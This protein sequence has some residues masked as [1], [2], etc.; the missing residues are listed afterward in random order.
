VVAIVTRL[1][2]FV[3]G[4][5]AFALFSLAVVVLVMRKVGGGSF[6]E[7]VG[8]VLMFLT[9]SIFI[10]QVISQA[11]RT[12]RSSAPPL[13]RSLFKALDVLQFSSIAPPP[14]CLD[15]LHPFQEYLINYSVSMLLLLIAVL[16]A[17]K[18]DYSVPSRQVSCVASVYRRCRPYIQRSTFILLS[19]LYVLT[20]NSTLEM[21]HCK[22]TVLTVSRYLE[23]DQHGAAIVELPAISPSNIVACE[24]DPRGPGCDVVLAHAAMEIKVDV[25]DINPQYVCYEKTHLQVIWFAYLTLIVYVIGYPVGSFLYVRHRIRGTMLKGHS[26]KEWN[27]ALTAD[28][29]RRKRYVDDAPNCGIRLIRVIRAAYFRTGS[30][31]EG[32][33]RGSRGACS[34]SCM[35]FGL[36]IADATV[37]KSPNGGGGATRTADDIMDENADIQ[38]DTAISPFAADVYRTSFFYQRHLD[39]LCLAALSFLLVFAKHHPRLQLSVALVVLAIHTTSV[40]LGRPFTT[41]ASFNHSVRVYANCLTMLGALVSFLSI[42]KDGAV[43]SVPSKSLN[44]LGPLSYVML[45]ACIGLSLLLLVSFY[46]TLLR[47]ARLD[48]ERELQ[49]RNFLASSSRRLPGINPV[50]DN[51]NNR[52]KTPQPF[53]RRAFA[54]LPHPGADDDLGPDKSGQRFRRILGRKALAKTD[55]LGASFMPRKVRSED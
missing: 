18:G 45:A 52:K 26:A 40:L 43:G 29:M 16:L 32:R 35:L 13:I 22:T 42:T 14:D 25:L 36:R 21:L 51:D 20:V 19:L 46:S 50:H 54:L 47:G 38:V 3:G 8:R 6:R 17:A 4:I 33:V 9:A 24:V 7:S 2:L 1:S 30:R 53:M 12:L 11:T 34:L 55:V 5:L 15:K 28:R 41:V 48:Q 27:A 31:Y 39:L 44:A 23:L 49:K 37:L 10:L